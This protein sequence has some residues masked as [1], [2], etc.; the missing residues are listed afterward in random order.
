RASVATSPCA[1]PIATRPTRLP[2]RRSWSPRR[3][4]H[5]TT[6]AASR[7]CAPQTPTAPKRSSCARSRWIPRA[8][9]PTTTWPSS[10]AGTGST[11]RQRPR[12]SSSTGAS[13]TPTPTASTPSWDTREMS[14]REG[15]ANEKGTE[16]AR[17][18]RAAGVR[19][20][21][22]AGSGRARDHDDARA[23][24]AR[25][26]TAAGCDP[27]R[28]GRKP[29]A[30]RFTGG[31]AHARRHPHRGRDPGAAGAVHH[32]AGPAPIHGVP[33]S[34]LYENESR[35]GSWH[36]DALSR[37]GA[38]ARPCPRKGERAM[39]EF[40]GMASF[41]KQGGL[42][43]Y[44]I[45]GIGVVAAAIALERFLVITGASVLNGK[46]L[47]NDVIAQISRGDLNAARNVSRKSNAPAAQVVQAVL[48]VP[49]LEESKLQ[50][51]ADDAAA[52][53]MPPLTRRLAHLN[54]LANI[55]TL[56]GLLGTISG[57]ITA[58][59]AVGAA[60]P[61]QRSAFLAGGISM[62][63]NAT[64]FGL[65]VAIP[66]LVTQ[67]FLVGLVEGIAEQVEESGIRVSR[68]LL[69]SVARGGVV[70]MPARTGPQAAPAARGTP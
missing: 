10:S 21:V 29:R 65:L 34:S 22:R 5:S 31:A 1:A 37:R 14:P 40:A 68:A 61:S 60:D 35:A 44:G 47:T 49:E 15:R 55:A 25:V 52:L 63:L 66:T 3:A 9:R 36:G 54:V 64:A 27:A 62:A 56:V 41:F 16:S 46:K 51:A 45:L 7:S 67:G 30:P 19:R 23:P 6:T 32:R 38:R 57:L 42:A 33:A 39:N 70:A 28:H 8:P 69:A 12:A 50:S 4:P 48:S 26:R 24:P 53:A 20:V 59:A 43:M 2:R 11:P 18:V 17:F 13:L 58:F